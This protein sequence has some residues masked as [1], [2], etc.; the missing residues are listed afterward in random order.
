M[1]DDTFD[2]AFATPRPALVPEVVR[3]KGGLKAIYFSRELVEI[4]RATRNRVDGAVG[5]CG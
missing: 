5:G 4:Q 2:D 1:T 3:L